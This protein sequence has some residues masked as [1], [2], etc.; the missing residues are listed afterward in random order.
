SFVEGEEM[1]QSR[2]TVLTVDPL[3]APDLELGRPPRARR[4][5]HLRPV[6]PFEIGETD[7]DAALEKAGVRVEPMDLPA[8]RLVDGHALLRAVRERGPRSDRRAA[9]EHDLCLTVAVEIACSDR[10]DGDDG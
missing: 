8:V 6:V 7:A 9:A 2:A 1:S 5:D 10:G 3:L 4:R